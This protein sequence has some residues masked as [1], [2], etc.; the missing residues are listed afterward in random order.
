MTGRLVTGDPLCG[1]MRRD[2]SECRAGRVRGVPLRPGQRPQHLADSTT[3]H[4]SSHSASTARHGAPRRPHDGPST[5]DGDFVAH[6][7]VAS[8]RLDCHD[9]RRPSILALHCLTR[10]EGKLPPLP[11]MVEGTSSSAAAR[12]AALSVNVYANIVPDIVLLSPTAEQMM[13]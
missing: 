8:P 1:P 12:L 2:V 10:V 6:K 5:A 9:H 7:A 11:G 13:Y 4:R 3:R